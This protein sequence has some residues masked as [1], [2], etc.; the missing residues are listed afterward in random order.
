MNAKLFARNN[1]LFVFYAKNSEQYKK[2]RFDINKFLISY[3]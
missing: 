1:T 3:I 2:R